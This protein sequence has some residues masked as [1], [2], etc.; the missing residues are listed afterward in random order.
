MKIEQVVAELFEFVS[1]S[2]RKIGQNLLGEF[3]RGEL[4]L[5]KYLYS[6][7]GSAWPST[8]S[9][10]MQTSTARVTVALKS[11]EHKGLISK[12]FD[13]ND[14][15]RKIVHLTPKG[16]EYFEVYIDKARQKITMV[17]Q[18]LG[19]EDATEYLRIMKRIEEISRNINSNLR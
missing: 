16:K 15:R 11:L 7:G 10:A 6:N 8:M 12:E 4:F 3:S 2:P 1:E 9:D 18:E 19:E 5:L 13:A 17:F 14:G